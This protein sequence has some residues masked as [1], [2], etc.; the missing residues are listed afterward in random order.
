MTQ[1]SMTQ[2][3][4]S[5][6]ARKRTGRERIPFNRRWL[7]SPSAPAHTRRFWWIDAQIVDIPVNQGDF[8]G[9]TL[10]TAGRKYDKFWRISG[11]HGAANYSSSIG[12]LSPDH[13]SKGGYGEAHR[14]VHGR[15][16]IRPK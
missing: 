1:H 7:R 16:P 6:N 9:S 8:T 11:L 4:G 12:P 3:T 15:C 5:L 13:E 14:F 2:A 10:R